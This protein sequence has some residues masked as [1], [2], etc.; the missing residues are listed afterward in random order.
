MNFDSWKNNFQQ[1]VFNTRAW[2]WNDDRQQ[3]Y[4]HQFTPEQPDLNYKEQRVVDAMKEVLTF[5]LDKGADGF[6][7]DAINFLFEDPAMQSE[8]LSGL[9]IDPNNYAHTEHIYTKD[10]VR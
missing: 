1:S 9:T 5:W 6:R 2:K 7:I 3:Y 8:P 4:L 10:L